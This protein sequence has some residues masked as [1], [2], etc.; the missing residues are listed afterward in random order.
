M[1]RGMMV[2][3]RRKK[4]AHATPV[5]K[6]TIA[7]C[8]LIV[9]LVLALIIPFSIAVSA[10][11]ASLS[12]II[13]SI[14][15]ALCVLVFFIR[16]PRERIYIIPT[17]LA[18]CFGLAIPQLAFVVSANKHDVSLSFD[19]LAY[20]TFSGETTIQPTKM[21]TYKRDNGRPMQ[22]AYYEAAN[23]GQRPAV[24]LLHGGGWRYGNHLE[25]GNWPKLLTDAG[26][27]VFSVEYRLSNDTYQTWRDAPADIHQAFTY[28]QD[29]APALSVA[30]NYIHIMGQSAGGHLALLEAYLHNQAASVVSLYAPIDLSLDYETSRDKSA[31]LD[32][33]GGPP[34][35]Y[36]S[37]YQSVSPIT[38]VS[39]YAPRTLIVQ[40]TTDDLVSPQNATRLAGALTKNNVDHET[41]LLPM[42]G[43]SFENQ[44]GGFATQIAE[45]SVV[46]FLS[47]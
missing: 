2:Y 34:S 12:A 15:I 41:V 38:Y 5:S 23:G 40:G 33:L 11:I 9:V 7:L 45:Q 24:L 30:S 10:G 18:A 21:I 29:N 27:H 26:F 39:A 46:R 42:T 8:G 28:L 47:Q 14:S 6:I 35:Q 37:R 1:A 44:R 43:H 25:T 16:P 36:A 3:M 32:L 20:V 4:S 31:E 19:P 22:L 17:L 13:F